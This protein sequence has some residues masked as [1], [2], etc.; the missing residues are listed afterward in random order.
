MPSLSDYLAKNYLSADP[1]PDKKSKKRKRKDKDGASTGLVI[2]DD[3]VT[4]WDNQGQDNDDDDR[5]PMMG[6]S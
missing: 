2:A 5:G 3:D 6:K 1:K 4:G